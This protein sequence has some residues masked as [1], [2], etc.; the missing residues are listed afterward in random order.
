MTY[1]ATCLR[2]PQPW[3]FGPHLLFTSPNTCLCRRHSCHPQT[4]YMVPK[5]TIK[6]MVEQ[7]WV[8]E[9][10]IPSLRMSE[11]ARGLSTASPIGNIKEKYQMEGSWFLREG[12]TWTEGGQ[13][14]TNECVAEGFQSCTAVG[15]ITP[16]WEPILNG[17]HSG[18][19][20]QRPTATC[21]PAI[22]PLH[23]A[24]SASHF[25][26]F[27]SALWDEFC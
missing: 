3:H 21:R 23:L 16:T 2:P 25:S 24:A 15:L 17:H 4:L 19:R 13:R 8:E 9:K 11:R 14:I 27:L 1:D 12:P 18:T 26:G 20:E 10:A 6:A 5:P 22:P 7:D